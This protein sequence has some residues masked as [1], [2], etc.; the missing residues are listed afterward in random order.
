LFLS[1][2]YFF[3]FFFLF[4]FTFSFARRR[5]HVNALAFNEFVRQT[6]TDVGQAAFFMPRGSTKSNSSV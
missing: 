5:A 6:E 4:F 3:S 1:I 2:F